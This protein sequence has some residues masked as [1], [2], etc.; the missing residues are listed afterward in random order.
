MTQ[1]PTAERRH[2]GTVGSSG[3]VSRWRGVAVVLASC[4]LASLA[5]CGSE[6]G[7]PAAVQDAAPAATSAG[8]DPAG[9]ARSG[10]GARRPLDGFGEVDFR[11]VGRDGSAFVGCAL[12]ADDPEA[13]A[14]GLMGQRDL[15]GYDAMVFRFDRPSTAG[16]Y[17]FDT[18]L[19]LSIAYLATDGT[20]VSSVDMDPCGAEEASSCPTFEPAGP[21][22]H[23]V[24]V[25]QGDLPEL[26]IVPGAVVTFGDGQAP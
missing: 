19:P 6:Q 24:E 20:L 25:A 16:F 14:Q 21:Y 17:M 11:V 1:P 3:R 8:A 22:R 4:S 10:S 5:G 23:A 2:H 9:C 18:V 15:R 12:L 13:R 26:G 7:D